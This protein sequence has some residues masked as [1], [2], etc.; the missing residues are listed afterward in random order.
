[1]PG[2][3]CPSDPKA[4]SALFP[5]SISYRATTG[6]APDGRDGAFAPGRQVPLPAIEAADGLAYTAAFAERLVGSGRN[7]PGLGNY[8]LVRGPVTDQGCLPPQP[9][10]WRGDAGSNWVASDWKSTLYNHLR[11]PGASPSCLADDARTA[12]MN[13]SSGH[14]D[15]VNVLIFDGSVRTMTPRIDL[16]IW[17]AWA[18]FAE[19][20]PE[21]AS[22]A[23][24]NPG[25]KE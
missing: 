4:T 1:V 7:E 24:R 15:G 16:N 9:S 14:V 17:R 13:A 10:A 25:R 11:P 18:A 21:P 12:S 3:V 23:P 22:S 19:P 8:T 5:A 20:K 6:A 2:F